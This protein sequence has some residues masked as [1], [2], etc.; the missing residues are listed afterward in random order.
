MKVIL[1]TLL[2]WTL[3]GLLS[4]LWAIYKAPLMDNDG[5]IIG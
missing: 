4:F 2:I 5:N 3:I 1:V